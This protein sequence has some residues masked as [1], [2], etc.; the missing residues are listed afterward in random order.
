MKGSKLAAEKGKQLKIQ[1]LK[2]T[3]N[4][5]DLEARGNTLL[6]IS[7]PD[8]RDKRISRENWPN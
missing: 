5:W 1:P 8:I 6:E 3:V 2:F 7:T 4:L